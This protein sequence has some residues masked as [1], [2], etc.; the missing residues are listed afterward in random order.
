MRG[1]SRIRVARQRA[2]LSQWNL[3]EQ[4]R[5]SRSAV[6]NW[7]CDVSSPR[8]E[9][10]QRLAIVADVSFE[11]LAT[12]RGAIDPGPAPD[13]VP[14]ADAEWVDDERELRLLRAFRRASRRDGLR[15]LEFAESRSMRK[16]HS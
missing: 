10:L 11:W 16:A 6:A 2:K 14:A 8:L 15:M 1:S 5:V 4:L 7:E 13:P 12:G 9:H 3:A